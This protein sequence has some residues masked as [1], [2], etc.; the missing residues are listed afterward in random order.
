MLRKGFVDTLFLHDVRKKFNELDIDKS[1]DLTLNEL[2][3]AMPGIDR[4]CK[5]WEEGG[6]QNDERLSVIDA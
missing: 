6:T 3:M 1:G 2:R 4:L 5:K